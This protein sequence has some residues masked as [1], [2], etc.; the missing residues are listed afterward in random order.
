MEQ[1]EIL[2]RITSEIKKIE[3]NAEVYLY[4]SRARGDFRND[5]DWDVLVITPRSE[6]TLE[7]E[8]ILRDPILNLEMETGE[9]ISTLVYTQKEWKAK[10]KHSSFFRNVMID[11][12]RI[13]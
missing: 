9:V 5:S 11:G 13:L 8:L 10:R 4:G 3:P 7:Y 1:S 12:F 2:N 6:I